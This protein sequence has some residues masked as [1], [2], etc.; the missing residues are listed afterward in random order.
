MSQPYWQQLKPYSQPQPP[1]GQAHRDTVDGD[2]P[3]GEDDNDLA[4]E[5]NDESPPQPQTFTASTAPETPA[6][7]K[8]KEDTKKREDA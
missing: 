4:I 8:P 1:G 3:S 2:W 6:V 7:E 5:E